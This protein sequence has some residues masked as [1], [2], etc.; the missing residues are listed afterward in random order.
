MPEEKTKIEPQ[1]AKDE[2]STH[3]HVTEGLS[4]DLTHFYDELSVKFPSIRVTSGRRESSPSGGFSHHH[5][6]DAID[7]GKEHTD[8]Y[9]YL[10]NTPEG[11]GL[12]TK[13]KLGILDETNPGTLE[14]TGGTGPHFHIGKDSAT[15]TTAQTRF[16][17]GDQIKPTA[18]FYEKNPAYDYAQPK[19]GQA[20]N[21]DLGYDMTNRGAQS[22][23]NTE[24]DIIIPNDQ[25]SMLFMA[26]V[27]KTEQKGQVKAQKEQASAARQQLARIQKEKKAQ[28]AQF[29]N[30]LRVASE[31]D[32]ALYTSRKQGR[33]DNS[34]P[35]TD[36][37][38]GI[39][40]QTTLPELPSIFS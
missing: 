10:Y 39:D 37:L 21:E 29:L 32:E 35:T 14:K 31:G 25:A 17:M 18:S 23:Q 15:A 40:V 7:I 6:G 20:I 12:M 13:Y 2:H 34:V 4:D 38:A 33:E 11:L 26:E 27:K 9:D 19:V 24:I 28:Q 16:A 22:F 3:N 30:T 36:P 5:H 1:R 8:V